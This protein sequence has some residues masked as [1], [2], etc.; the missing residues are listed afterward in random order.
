MGKIGLISVVLAAV[1]FSSAARAEGGCVDSRSVLSIAPAV[2]LTTPL[3]PPRT[4]NN[5]G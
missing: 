4:A 1:V 3:A 5:E 2:A